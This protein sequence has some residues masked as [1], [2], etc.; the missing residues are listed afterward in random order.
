M[1]GHTVPST[2][3]SNK[4]GPIA[5]SGQPRM[6]DNQRQRGSGAEVSPGLKIG[7]VFLEE[8]SH[9]CFSYRGTEKLFSV[10]N[11]MHHFGHYFPVNNI[12]QPWKEDTNQ[13]AH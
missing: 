3:S 6:T 1:L 13:C 2:G 12:H 8:E 9:H 4:E 10:D 5:D 11:I 7:H